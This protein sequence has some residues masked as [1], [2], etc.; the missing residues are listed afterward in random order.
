MSRWNQCI[1][2]TKLFTVFAIIM[3]VFA[4]VDSSAREFGITGLSQGGCG[5]GFCHGG[6]SGATT[7]AL[8]GPRDVAPGALVNYTFTVA[9]AANNFSGFN[10]SL[11]NGAGGAAGTLAAGANSHVEN[12]QLTHNAPTADGAGGAAEFPF[13][14]MAPVDHGVYTFYGAG[15]AVNNNGNADGGDVHNLTGGI[16]I[17]VKGATI[18]APGGGTF[19]RGTNLTINWTQTGFQNFRIELSNNNFTTSQVLTNSV[20]ATANTFIWAIPTTQD[21]STSYAIRLVNTADGQEVKRSNT[22]TIKGPPTITTQPQSQLVC[23]GRTLQL[24]VSSDF[25]AATFQWRKDGALI[26]G[27]TAS[28]YQVGVAKAADAG[29]YDVQVFGCNGT[30]T[31]NAA[32]VTIGLR[33]K[34]TLQ[35]TGKNVCENDSVS[36]FADGDGAGATYQWYRNGSIMP[37]KNTKTLRFALILLA[38]EASYSLHVSGTCLPDAVSNE[39]IVN[40][41]E[42]PA[43]TVQPTDKNLKVGDTLTLNVDGYGEGITYQWKKNGAVIPGATQKIYRKTGIVR[44]DSGQ[45]EAVITNQCGTVTSRKAVVRIVPADGPGLP[46]LASATLELGTIPMCARID[47][48]LA[49][50]LKN[51]GGSALTVTS[52]SADPPSL[53]MAQGSATPYV[54]APGAGSDLQLIVTPTAMG[55]ITG[56]VTFF[57]SNGSAVFQVNGIAEAGVSV[58]QDTLMFL[59]GAADFS[60]CVSLSLDARCSTATVT[61]ARLEGVGAGSYRVLNTLPGMV[62]AGTP[63]EICV[64]TTS[65]SG[66][67]ASVVIETSAGPRTVQ[68]RRGVFSSVENADVA[69]ISIHPNP[70]NEGVSI[71]GL[72]QGASIR[73][74]S[75]QGAEVTNLTLTGST[76]ATELMWDGRDASGVPVSSGRYVIAVSANHTVSVYTLIIAR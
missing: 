24:T 2:S 58:N 40:V 18:T 39:A 28:A 51:A 20:A 63:L 61:Q 8:I 54:L 74:L 13:T 38:D 52:I 55:T 16:A 73:I 33:P 62:V 48:T 12:N 36:L 75:L 17:T 45:Y 29:S 31:S 5:G 72:P 53:L 49:G 19:C 11:V 3:L 4:V 32:E 7:V 50:L 37:G 57:T 34:I 1:Q 43:V 56:T 6:Q 65:G 26:P 67:D 68:L 41:I 15:N 27:A 10:V 59:E 44:A 14:W 69:V 9:H 22:F 47:T 25:G 66:G 70:A 30:S 64:Q 35:P 23:E 42:R 46:E 71:R 21:V 60:R 76:V